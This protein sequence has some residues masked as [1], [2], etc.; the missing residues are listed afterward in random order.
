MS[1]PAGNS[2]VQCSCCRVGD[3]DSVRGLANLFPHISEIKAGQ[4]YQYKIIVC[5]HDARLK[6]LNDDFDAE[7]KPFIEA[8]LVFKSWVLTDVNIKKAKSKNVPFLTYAPKSR[9]VANYAE[10]T[11]ELLRDV[12]S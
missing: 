2:A 9:A 12:H 8:G 11:E 4:H 7:I 5:N 6:I 1:V 10:V 3:S